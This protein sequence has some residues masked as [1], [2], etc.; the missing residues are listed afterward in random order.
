MRRAWFLISTIVLASAI[1][2]VVKAHSEQIPISFSGCGFGASFS[3]DFVDS[4]SDPPF[5]FKKISLGHRCGTIQGKYEREE[6]ENNNIPAGTICTVRAALALP[7]GE[8]VIGKRLVVRNSLGRALAKGK[9]DKNGEVR[10]RFRNRTSGSREFVLV[11]PRIP[12]NGFNLGCWVYR[13]RT[14]CPRATGVHAQVC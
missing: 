10:F 14:G 7:D 6:A 11:G 8:A 4:L 13:D 2:P 1:Q 5:I 9:T 3:G 12:T